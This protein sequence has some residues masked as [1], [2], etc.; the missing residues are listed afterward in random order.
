[1]HS[2]D[3]YLDLSHSNLI[4]CEIGE[5]LRLHS[6]QAMGRPRRIALTQFGYGYFK[7]ELAFGVRIVNRAEARQF[8]RGDRGGGIDGELS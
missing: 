7:L 5:P 3:T 1:M 6:G 8:P 2:R 4:P